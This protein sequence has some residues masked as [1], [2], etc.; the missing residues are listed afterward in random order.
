MLKKL[1]KII[2]N[3][4]SYLWRIRE[5]FIGEEDK[6]GQYKARVKA[7]IFEE[8]LKNTPLTVIF[9]VTENAYTGTLITG[10]INDLNLH[11]PRNIR[12]LIKEGLSRGWNPKKSQLTIEKGLQAYEKHSFNMVGI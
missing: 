10:N 12:M 2:V 4:V 3:D 6:P 7:I 5:K 1:R 9:N 8:G 11:K